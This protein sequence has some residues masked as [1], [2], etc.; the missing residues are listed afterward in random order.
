MPV[1]F[2]KAKFVGSFPLPVKAHPPAEGEGVEIIGE[3]MG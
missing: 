2:E 3:I 1:D